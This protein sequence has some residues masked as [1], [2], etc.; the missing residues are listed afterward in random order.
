MRMLEATQSDPG[1]GSTVL[2]PLCSGITF[3]GWGT[4]VSGR[5]AGTRCNASH[6][7]GNSELKLTRNNLD[8]IKVQ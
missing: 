7:T 5:I 8:V 6:V 4:E 2:F 3:P 1:E